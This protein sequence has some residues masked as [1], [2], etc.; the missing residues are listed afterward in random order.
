MR[1]P[2]A[3]GSI[4]PDRQAIYSRLTYLTLKSVITGPHTLMH[5][6]FITFILRWV[7]LTNN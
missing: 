3:Y 1:K 6:F 2:F 5:L 4:D 7:G